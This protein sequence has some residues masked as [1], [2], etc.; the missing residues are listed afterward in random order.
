MRDQ[1]TSFT[2]F[3]DRYGDTDTY[4]YINTWKKRRSTLSKCLFPLQQGTKLHRA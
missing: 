2:Y 1:K 4:M 3:F